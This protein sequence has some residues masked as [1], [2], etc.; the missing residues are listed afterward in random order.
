MI[1]RLSLLLSCLAL[2]SSAAGIPRRSLA[3]GHAP[4]PIS[5]VVHQ[6]PDPTWAENIAVRETG[7]LLVT[8]LS[9]PDLYLINP[10]AASSPTLLHN[11][12]PYSA[13]LGITEV[14]PDHFYVVTGNATLVPFGFGP[15]SYAVASVD[16]SSYDPVLN[17]A[18]VVKEVVKI[19]TAQGLNGMATLDASKGLVIISDAVQGVVYVLNVHTEEYSILLQEPEM[20]VPPGGELGING[21]KVLPIHGMDIVYIYFDNT[22]SSIFCR[23]PFSLST[24]QTTGPVETLATG[25]AGDDFTLDPE[26]G[27]AYIANGDTNSIDRIPL[28]GGKVTT[29]LGGVNQTIVEGPTSIALGRGL[30]DKGI[31]YI[32]TDGGL[33]QPINGTFTEGGRV[34]AVVV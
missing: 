10:L 8:I 6:F 21:V 29:I 12:A 22:S 33:L 18:P 20:A 26:E 13:L 30:T 9:T 23:V 14:Q 27:V 31:K 28:A 34:V 7:E 11:F 19:P 5:Y 3:Q 2:G 25:T 4:Q 17:T 1:S 15:G 16:L 24:L 32:T